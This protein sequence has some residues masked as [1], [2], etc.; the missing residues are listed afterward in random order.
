MKL[1]KNIIGVL[2]VICIILTSGHAFQ[3]I[4]PQISY[5][6][7]VGIFLF[8]IYVIFQKRAI[9][10]KRV[11]ALLI[12][13]T[14]I[15]FTFICEQTDNLNYYISFIVRI[16]FAYFIATTFSFRKVV[17]IY[18]KIMTVISVIALIG[19]I[20]FNTTNLVDYMPKLLNSNDVEYAIG[21]VFN[22]IVAL[23]DRNCAMFWEPGLFATALTVAMVFEILF[24]QKP[25]SILRILLFSV[26][27]FTANSSAGYILLFL[28]L[29]LLVFRNKKLRRDKPLRGV[30]NVIIVLLIVFVILNLDTIILSTPLK[31]N[32]YFVK[33]LSDNLVESSRVLA[34]WHNLDIFAQNPIFGA[35][36]SYVT[37]HM[38]YVAD[39]S[40]IT[41]LMSVFGLWGIAYALGWI[42]GI[43]KLKNIGIMSKLIL[44]VIVM[45]ILNK[46]PHFMFV[47]TWCLFFY[48][49]IR[50]PEKQTVVKLLKERNELFKAQVV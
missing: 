19:Y 10:V 23:P 9:N 2:L 47:F 21:I 39:T 7:F 18:L 20:L 3:T 24:K 30:V 49:L 6:A 38:Q 8:C 22:M 31:D 11:I 32:E 42:F 48:L 15:I 17:D 36:I 34:V 46:E 50:K 37:Q 14:P 45:A 16:I 33:L 43:F 29:S 28:C 40:T 35:G 27:Y 13:V 25:I 12:F 26:C 5:V 1:C 41:Y 4:Y 44:F